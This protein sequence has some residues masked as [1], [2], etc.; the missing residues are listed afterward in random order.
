MRYLKTVIAHELV[1]M[2]FG[3]LVTCDWWEYLWLNEGFAQYFEWIVIDSVIKY[4][5]HTLLIYDN[6][7]EV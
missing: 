5:E 6:D 7:N 4:F 2:W 3:N 1:H